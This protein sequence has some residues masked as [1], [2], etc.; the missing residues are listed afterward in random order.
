MQTHLADFVKGMPEHDELAGIIR[1]CVHCGFC[2]ATCP[3]YQLTGNELDGPRGRIYLLKQV[4][5]GQAVSGLTQQHLDNCLNC[6]AC[7]STCP[8]GVRYG[9]LLDLTLPV[10]DARV[11]RTVTRQIMRYAIKQIFPYRQCF[12]RLLTIT[13]WLKPVLP[14]ALKKKIPI[15]QPD[16][17]WPDAVHSRK[18]LLLTGCVQPT[19]AAGIDSAAARVLD[20]IGISLLPLPNSTCCGALN[21][22]LADHSQAMQFARQTIDVCW[23]YLEQGVEAIT[24]TASGCDLMLKDY[25]TL[26]QHD[27]DYAAKALQ[28]SARIKDLSEVLAAE[29]LHV[30]SADTRKIAF[31]SPCTL[32][33]GLKLG[34]VVENILRTIGFELVPVADGHLC[35]GSAGVYSLLQPD[36]SRLLLNNKLQALEAQQPDVIATANIGCLNHLQSAATKPVVHWLELLA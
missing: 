13:R 28:F 3:T 27:R 30:F 23:P 20:K 12:S 33:H 14:K 4:L 2:N 16:G 25:G 6:Q 11:K 31:Q 19:L 17:F 7:E 35:C 1:S 36:L 29:D 8:S 9:R 5:E 22:H 24:M 10:V 34:G 32:Q 18:I 21:Y 15:R 26:L